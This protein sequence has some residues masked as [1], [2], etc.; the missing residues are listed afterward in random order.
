MFYLYLICIKGDLRINLISKENS[1]NL[2]LIESYNLN[3]SL[4]DVPLFINKEYGLYML[5][6]DDFFPSL[7]LIANNKNEVQVP[8]I[9]AEPITWTD[10]STTTTTPSSFM[11][12]KP[13]ER[14]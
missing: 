4:K 7:I 12:K 2:Y 3:T 10:I 8:D 14:I 6:D 5:N 9:T 1:Y 11:H 13:G